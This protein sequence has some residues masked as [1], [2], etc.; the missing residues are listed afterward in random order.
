MTRN[1]A[2]DAD[3]IAAYDEPGSWGRLSEGWPETPYTPGK[4][5]LCTKAG[6]VPYGQYVVVGAEYVAGVGYDYSKATIRCASTEL[7][8]RLDSVYRDMFQECRR[9]I[10]ADLAQGV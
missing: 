5:L 8:D 4:M 7:R 2:T 9:Y 10:E 3:A 1:L 6:V